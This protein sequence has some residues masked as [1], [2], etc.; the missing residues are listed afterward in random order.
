MRTHV[1]ETPSNEK[2]F[3]IRDKKQIRTQRDFFFKPGAGG[4]I[5]LAQTAISSRFFVSTSLIKAKSCTFNTMN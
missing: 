3:S 5:V 2:Q 1:A 4:T